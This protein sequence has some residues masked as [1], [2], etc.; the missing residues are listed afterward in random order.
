MQINEI[1]LTGGNQKFRIDLGG[2]T[3]T[4]RTTWRD[5]AGWIMGV[6]DADGEPILMGV[7]VI[8]GVKL[9]EQYPHLGI[10]GAML[11][12]GAKDAPEYPGA[13]TLG[14]QHRLT[15]IQE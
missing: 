12:I 9:L 14:S 6:M 5:V 10:N 1:P 4:L 3:Y 8:P 7:P 15:F 13:N 11:L 2:T